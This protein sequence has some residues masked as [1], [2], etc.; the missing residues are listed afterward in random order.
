MPKNIKKSITKGF[1]KGNM[2]DSNPTPKLNI[3][4]KPQPTKRN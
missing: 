1:I 2:K 4:L 3:I